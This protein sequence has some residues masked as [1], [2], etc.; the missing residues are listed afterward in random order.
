M[1]KRILLAGATGF[2]GRHVCE[3]LHRRGDGVVALTRD[4]GSASKRLYGRARVVG[5]DPPAVGPW[6]DEVSAVDAVVNLAGEP[7]VGRWND[8]RKKVIRASRVDATRAIVEAI[9]KS[10]KKPSVLVQGCA[11]GIYGETFEEVDETAKAGSGWLAELCEDWEAEAKKAEE[12]G[13][14]VVILRTGIVLGKDGGALPKMIPPFKIGLGGPLGSG[15]QWMS[16]IAIK[17]MVGLVELALDDERAKGPINAV[18]PNPVTNKEFVTE[19]GDVLRR[20]SFIPTPEAALRLI[21]GEGADAVLKGQRVVPRRAIE[22]EYPW[23]HPSLRGAL[24][25]ALGEET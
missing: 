15:E 2:I 19:L 21:F 11:V 24:K 22:L 25:A 6:R 1:G 3:V 20:P 12:L 8:A 17:D 13:V 14:R 7:I 4:P 23:F 16:W 10:D 18:A 9:A 5:W